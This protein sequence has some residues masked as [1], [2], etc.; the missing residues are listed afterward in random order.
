MQMIARHTYIWASRPFVE[1]SATSEAVNMLIHTVND[2]LFL[3][4]TM[5]LL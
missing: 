4:V 3:R 1:I 5:S 2:S